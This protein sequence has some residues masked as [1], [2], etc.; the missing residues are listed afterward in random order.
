MAILSATLSNLACFHPQFIAFDDAE[1]FDEAAARLISKVRTIAA[2]SY[3]RSPGIAVHL[4]RSQFAIL[5]QL[6]AHDVLHPYQQYIVTP[7]VED[8][9][10]LIFILHADHEQNCST[11]TVRAVGSARANLFASSRP[12]CAPCG[13]RCTAGPT[14]K[15]SKCSNASTRAAVARGLHP[16]RQGQ[17]QSLPPLR[18]RPPR[19]SELR[20]P[21]EE[22]PGGLRQ[23]LR[24]LKRADPLLD[25]ARKLE[26]LALQDPYFIDRK[27]YPNV[28]FY[29]GMILARWAFRRTCSPFVLR[30]GVCPGGLPNGRSSTRIRRARFCVRGRFTSVRR[31][32]IMCR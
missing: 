32:R 8:A 12:A 13:A 19:L 14:W 31:R 10:N 21:G 16:R 17:G 9:L 23:G 26:E 25:I 24:Q 11:T 1:S 27:L 22:L 18:L 30:S 6:P 2:F 29:S 5:R 20:S 3:R 15:S 7:E 4:S 28:D